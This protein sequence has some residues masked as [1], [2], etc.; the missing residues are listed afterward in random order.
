[1]TG[2]MTSNPT[3]PWR[4]NVG[5][6]L[7]NR[8]GK[9][10]I[11]RRADLPPDDPHPWQLPQG[12]IDPGEA[13]E[14]AALREL[15][16]E[17]GTDAATIIGSI[18]DWLTYDFPA[19]AIARFGGVHRGQR[20]RWFA[21]RFTGTDAMIRLDTH[22]HPEFSEWRWATLTD[23]P[24]LAVPFKHHIYERVATDFAAFAVPEGNT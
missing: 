7:F 11:A 12:G 18:D 4:A 8:A 14:A 10:L 2:E 5:I 21:L 17:V 24:A 23:I 16:E 19:A 3:L 6:A 22:T 15:H 20:Q 13:P 1:M 9:V